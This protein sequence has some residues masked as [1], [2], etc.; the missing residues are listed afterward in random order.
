MFSKSRKRGGKEKWCAKCKK[1]NSRKSGEEVTCFKSGK[2]WHYADECT[3]NERLCYACNEEG[4]FMQD[5]P[6]REEP[7]KPTVPLKHYER[8]D[9][10]VTCYKCGMKGH[11]ANKCT[12][13]NKVCYRCNKEG[14][15]SRDCP[16]KNEPTKPKAFHTILD[17]AENNARIQE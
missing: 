9:E 8:C 5:C 10:E 4:H 15:F 11:Y 2:H 16:K 1:E 14:H 13:D 17:E 12:S 6:K 7:T 3:F